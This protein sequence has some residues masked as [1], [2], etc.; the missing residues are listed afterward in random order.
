MKY[1]YHI[2]L[3]LIL[4]SS[5]EGCKKIIDVPPPVGNIAPARIFSS[6][7]QATAAAA[8]IYFRMINFFNSY[9]AGSMTIY[10]GLSADEF[11]AFDQTPAAG[12]IQYQQNQIPATDLAINDFLWGNM[13]STIYG[14][15]SVLEG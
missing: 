4:I 7:D 11:I 10:P 15:N 6:D 3:A 1:L 14:S 9:A 2:S 12:Y 8:G 13:Y 5:F